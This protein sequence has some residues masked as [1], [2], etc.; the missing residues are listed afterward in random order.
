[1]EAVFLKVLN[2]SITAG[3]LVIAVVVL[4]LILKKAPKRINCFLWLLVGVRLA[5]PFSLESP[6]SLIPSA[7]PIPE[8]ILLDRTPEIDSGVDVL[9]SAVNPII[10]KA[11]A[12][13]GGAS[14]NPLQIFT[15]IAMIIWITGIF[16]ML[17][18]MAVSYFRL[19]K[20]TGEA[21]TLR[22][23]IFICDRIGSPFI[24]G[25]VR[26]KIYLPSD[27][28]EADINYVLGH[29]E[30]HLKRLDHIWKPLGYLLLSVYWFNPILWTAYYLLCRDIEYACDEKVIEQ[31]GT[32]VKKPYSEALI[33][34]SIPRRLISACPLAFG[35]T[36]VKSR[37]RSVLNYKKPTFWI[38]AISI[39]ACIAVTACFLTNPS[40]PRLEQY[41]WHFSHASIG[42]DVIYRSIGNSVKY[43]EA[44]ELYLY[45]DIEDGKILLSDM[46]SASRGWSF[47]YEIRD[48][49][50][51]TTVYR[52]ENSE[53]VGYAVVTKT[54]EY[55]DDLV[56]TSFVLRSDDGKMNMSF[57]LPNRDGMTLI[58]S[59]GEYTLYFSDEKGT[60][61]TTVPEIT[62]IPDTAD[63]GTN[64]TVSEEI[65]L[66]VPK[67]VLD[68]ALEQVEFAYAEYSSYGESQ[69]AVTGTT[70]TITEAKLVA[71]EQIN[72]GTS[73]LDHSINIYEIEFHLKPSQS[74]SVFL[75]GNMVLE[76]GW[77][78]ITKPY[79]VMLCISGENDTWHRL[80]ILDP[81]RLTDYAAPETLEKY[82]NVYTAA[83]MEMYSEYL[84]N[85]KLMN[86]TVT[87]TAIIKEWNEYELKL[88]IVE[89]IT[90]EDTTRMD[91]LGLTFKD[92]PNG[93]YIHNPD[94]SETR[95]ILS[96]NTEYVFFD[97]HEKFTD[98][99]D[100]RYEVSERFVTTNDISVFIEYLETYDPYPGMPFFF[101]GTEDELILIEEK[102]I[103]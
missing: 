14:V 28:K 45:F 78:K 33:N 62:N 15:F 19:K 38:I 8:K 42:E 97:W 10:S 68:Y 31:M 101:T 59:F 66:T 65:S 3:W 69:S 70:Y 82:G 34:C 7:E 43:P 5:V 73:S 40:Y 46:L 30:A 41:D 25:L 9:N 53:T 87:F 79:L 91:E 61:E 49:A 77:F 39:I 16:V 63:T 1:M 100:P 24:L 13:S 72:T 56:G 52:L 102:I 6:L 92:M 48:K 4:R 35:E 94:E 21:I 74:E 75:A 93:Y 22:D 76:D 90:S 99:N 64:I 60:A 18:Y 36:S 83:A 103:M 86:P 44:E 71:I 84:K 26:P 20:K 51:K 47:S 11:F 12:P 23:N 98:E 54:K 96:Q 89:Y 57:S 27:I 85:T 17:L 95:I 80:G 50:N 55:S 58:L 37:I 67:P 32:E 29:E 2:T 81:L 88:D